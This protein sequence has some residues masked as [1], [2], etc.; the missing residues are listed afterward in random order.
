VDGTPLDFQKAT[1][2]GSRIDQMKGEPGGY[3]HNYVLNAEGNPRI[4]AIGSLFDPKT[5]RLM[6]ASTTEPGVQLYSG[7][8]LDGKLT[9]K[10]GAVYK[11]HAGLCLEAQHYPDAVNQPKFPS[12][13]LQPGKAYK[14]TT[15]YKFSTK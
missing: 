15:V 12:I 1:A 9:G 2:I 10:G 14:Q 11:K 4:I 13:I 7:N 3:D 8:Y 5:G 6:E